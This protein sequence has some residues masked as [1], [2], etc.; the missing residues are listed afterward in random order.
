MIHKSNRIQIQCIHIKPST[1]TNAGTD[2]SSKCFVKFNEPLKNT[3]P[4]V[5]KKASN[6][7]E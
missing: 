2:C 4:I 6:P 3:F 1:K 7:L 5:S